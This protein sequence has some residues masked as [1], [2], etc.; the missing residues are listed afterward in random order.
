MRKYHNPLFKRVSIFC[1]WI[2]AAVLLS[3]VTL[4]SKELPPDVGLVTKLSGDVS[5]SNEFEKGPTEKALAFMKIRESDILTLSQGASITLIYFSNG[6][7]EIWRGPVTLSV[8]QEKSQPTSGDVGARIPQVKM[9]PTGVAGK[10]ASVDIPFPRGRVS[11]SGHM[12][13]RGDSSEDTNLPQFTNEIPDDIA[14]E[15]INDAREEYLRL[16]KDLGSESVTPEI[17]LLSVLAKHRQYDEMQRMVNEMLKKQ[18]NSDFI[19]DLL[20][21]IKNQI[22]RRVGRHTKYA[23]LIGIDDYDK[24]HFKPLHG[25]KN[26]IDLIKEILIRRF[27]YAP[28]N[29]LVLKDNEASHTKIADTFKKLN[30]LMNRGDMAYIHYSGHGSYTCDL[31][32]DEDSGWDKDSTWVSYG[33]RLTASAKENGRDCAAVRAL[34]KARSSEP[35]APVPPEILDNYD[36]LDDEIN[37]WLALL[38]QK[39]HRIV[40]ISD[41]C[42]SGTVTRGDDA[43]RTRGLPVDLRPH[44]LG[45]KVASKL[46]LKGI[47]ITACRD[48]EKASEYHFG[49]RV[50]GMFTWFWAKSLE[51]A[52]PDDTWGDVHKR[53]TARLIYQGGRQHP[54]IEGEQGQNVFN[55]DFSRR[56]KTIPVRHVSFDGKTATID[57]GSLVGVTPGS[58][59]RKYAPKDQTEN[60][61]N[62]RITTTHAI[63]SKGETKGKFQVG[64]LVVLEHYQHNVAPSRIVVRTD[65]EKD[66]LL[67]ARIETAVEALPAFKVVKKGKFDFVLQILRPRKDEVGQYIFE[68]KDDSLPKSFEEQ[69]PECWD[70]EPR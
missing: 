50:H 42:H 41:S 19:K 65:M 63:W 53:G 1:F 55:G 17:F 38:S 49:G 15:E 2:A 40:F 64:D 58:I 25:A 57:A 43:M 16:K 32:G 36:I 60:E 31:N 69:S 52:G 13:I 22:S 37:S 4:Y 14:K 46:P 28:K 10:I 56:K 45:K 39:T 66:H 47:R 29:I 9:V 67:A 59:Y 11:H 26:D 54:R 61:N 24:G 20:V 5:Y 51:E 34:Q 3:N 30:S 12:Q 35:D 44:P 6:R 27:N 18:P 48:D 68:G 23:L 33:S 21:W 7:Q 70:L 62:I 8:G